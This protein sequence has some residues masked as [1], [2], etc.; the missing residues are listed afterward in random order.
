MT[1]R[2]YNPAQPGS[3]AGLPIAERYLNLKGNVK[4]V[5]IRQD[6]YTHH[7]PIRHRFRRRQ[8]FTKGIYDLWQ[9]DLVDMHSLSLHNDDLKYLLTCIDTFSKYAWVRPLKNKSEL[10][11]IEAFESILR[12]KVPLYLETDKG[13]EFK[14]TLFQGQLSEYKIKFYTSENDDIK[15]AIVER[16]NRTLKTRMYR[17]FA[18]SK[19]YRYVD[20]LQDLVHSY[21]H[22][23]HS[24]IRMSPASVNV[25][26][27]GLDRRK[28]FYK[29]PEKTKMAVRHRPTSENQQAKASIRERLLARMVGRNFHHQ[30]EISHYSGHLRYQIRVR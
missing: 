10:C 16:F 13:T 30:Q 8:I 27:E 15:A 5:L 25:K 11:V 19:S 26:N 28:L 7:R 22:T 23:Y 18:H 4:D 24:S 20:V 29:H 1:D 14:N 21:N 2:Y 17:Y 9:A 3:F 6:A 12:E